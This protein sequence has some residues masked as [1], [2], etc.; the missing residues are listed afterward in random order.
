MISLPEFKFTKID[1]LVVLDLL[2]VKNHYSKGWMGH[3]FVVT[4]NL[5]LFFSVN[6]AQRG[7]PYRGGR[8][9]PPGAGPRGP[10]GAGPRFQ[11][12]GNGNGYAPRPQN[13]GAQRYERPNGPPGKPSIGLP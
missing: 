11:Q 7:G 3:F 13:G 5:I 2:K 6:M 4:S 8:G 10:P 1:L 12:N 9:G